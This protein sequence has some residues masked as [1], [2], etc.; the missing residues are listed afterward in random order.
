MARA[1]RGEDKGKTVVD[2]DGNEVGTISLV[3]DDHAE[4]DGTPDLTG[5]LRDFL[6]WKDDDDSG[7]LKRDHIDEIGDDKVRLKNVRG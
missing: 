5:A 6:G 4:M 1:F 2:E 3:E 7:Q